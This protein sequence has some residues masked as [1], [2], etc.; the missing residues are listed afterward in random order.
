M[1]KPQIQ[2]AF[3]T[4]TQTTEDCLS[5][6]TFSENK[7]QIQLLVIGTAVYISTSAE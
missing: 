2:E 6:F 4:K 1:T 5:V 3:G 7:V